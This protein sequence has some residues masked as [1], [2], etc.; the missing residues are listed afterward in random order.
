MLIIL[1]QASRPIPLLWVCD[2]S[3]SSFTPD[4]DRWYWTHRKRKESDVL[5]SPCLIQKIYTIKWTGRGQRW[6]N[7]RD[8]DDINW[9]RPKK[10]KRV[11]T[12]SMPQKILLV[13]WLSKKLKKLEETMRPQKKIEKSELEDT[14]WHQPTIFDILTSLST[15]DANTGKCLRN[16]NLY[17]WLD[18][19][20]GDW[21]HEPFTGMIYAFSNLYKTGGI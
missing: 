20:V 19:D 3:S 5:L 16:L 4:C 9:T 11:T 8:C 14:K 13:Y 10:K 17:L 7:R 1:F 2:R 6:K 18:N 21:T 15:K 12:K